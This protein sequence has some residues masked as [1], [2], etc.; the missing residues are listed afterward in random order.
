MP[1]NTLDKASVATAGQ[2]GGGIAGLARE[3]RA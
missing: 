2:S 3:A 1:C